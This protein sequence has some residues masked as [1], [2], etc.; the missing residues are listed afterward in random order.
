MNKI[1][2]FR[3]KY[4]FLSNF[5]FS[6]I[7]YEGIQFWNVESA[8]QAQKCESKLEKLK[9]TK[10]TPTEAKA[11]GRKVKLRSDWEEVKLGIM[12]T[13][14]RE[15]FSHSKDLKEMLLETGDA[16]LEEGNE[17]NDTFWGVCNGKGENHLGKILM[18]IRE[19]LK[20]GD[21]I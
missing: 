14:V 16:I 7:D 9:F 10:K 2:S 17:W 13:L 20:H 1:T 11:L 19:E 18:K 21:N 4:A 3:G 15:K 6:P 12:E 5:F 8:F